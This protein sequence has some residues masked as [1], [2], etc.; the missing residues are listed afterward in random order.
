MFLL[1]DVVVAVTLFFLYSHNPA[2]LCGIKFV[3]ILGALWDI[4]STEKDREIIIALKRISFFS[5]QNLQFKT[6]YNNYLSHSVLL[7]SALSNPCRLACSV[8]L[9]PLTSLLCFF[10]VCLCNC[11][12]KYVKN[13]FM[14]SQHSIMYS[15]LR[16]KI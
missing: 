7:I 3:S 13:L 6:C 11:L 12:L 14:W 10:R 15:E 1:L 9:K 8:A 16:Q 2:Q 4:F 5:K